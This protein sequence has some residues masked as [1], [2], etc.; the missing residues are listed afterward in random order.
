[1]SVTRDS[2]LEAFKT[3]V[4]LR[5]YAAALGYALDRR[6]SW[7]GSSVPRNGNGD[8]VIVK[9]DH[10]QHYVYFSVRDESDNGSIIDFAMRRK[11]LNLGQVRKELRPWIGKE[12]ASL[13]AFPALPVSTKDRLE[14]DNAFRRMADASRHPYLESERSLPGGLL[15]AARFAGRIKIDGFGNA[16]FPHFDLEGLCGYEIKNRGFTGFARGGEKGLWLSH[17]EDGDNRLVL[18]ESAIDALSHAALFPAP[19]TRY[20]SIGG[21]KEAV[22]LRS[23]AERRPNRADSMHLA[24]AKEWASWLGDPDICNPIVAWVADRD[25]VVDA[26]WAAP[27]VPVSAANKLHIRYIFTIDITLPG[28]VLTFVLIAMPARSTSRNNW[29]SYAV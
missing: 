6:E 28:L 20:A 24:R 19:A 17:R 26:R 16:V 9:K 7:R 15:S 13:T 29:P 5:A 27:A 12:T 3:A 14:V 11:N 8:K 18:A 4:D 25:I 22:V 21:E 23:Q 1:M 10:D 2:E